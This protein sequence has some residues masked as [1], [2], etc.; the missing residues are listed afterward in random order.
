MAFLLRPG[1]G[2]NCF[3]QQSS[4]TFANLGAAFVEV[5]NA[6]RVIV[7]L[8]GFRIVEAWTFVS[9]AGVSGVLR[10]EYATTI[11]LVWNTLSGDVPLSAVGPQRCPIHIPIPAGALTNAVLVRMVGGLGN[12]TEDPQVM[13]TSFELIP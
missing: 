6:D 11:P 2:P 3:L 7:D 10:L 13:G 12:G 4:R 1:H 5:N 9:V 8:R